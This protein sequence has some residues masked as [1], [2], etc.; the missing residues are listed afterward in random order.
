M[1]VL[2]TSGGTKIPIDSVRHIGNMSS[3]TFGAKIA[4]EA[5]RAGHDVVFLMASGS[6]SPLGLRFDE[7]D[8][9]SKIIRKTFGNIIDRIRFRKRI[10]LVRYSTFED[11]ESS[12][13]MEACRRP[14]VV[15][16][17]AA[18]SDYDVANKVNGKIRTKGDMSIELKPLPKLIS[19]FKLDAHGGN[20][21]PRPPV[22][23]GFKLL[24]GSDEGMLLRAAQESV[25]NN[26]CDM[27]IAN[28]LRDIKAG[29]HKL[30]VVLPD[31]YYTLRTLH[32]DPNYLAR[33]VV[34]KYTWLFNR[35]NSKSS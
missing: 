31:D 13:W 17:A 10:H 6:K 22:L 27:V 32:G 34:R 1:K 11:Y 20:T 7:D 16:L 29:E 2:I 14:D 23:V 15:V 12:L 28:D 33:E 19:R 9:I 26:G 4:Y 8:S 30:L 25:R 35:K 24:V 21:Y 3:G 5:L 18:V